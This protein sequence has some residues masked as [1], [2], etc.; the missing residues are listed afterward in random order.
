MVYRFPFPAFPIGWFRVAKSSDVRPGQ[1]KSIHY[2]GRNLVLWRS[3]EGTVRLFDS[4]CSHLGA[5]VGQG[6]VVENMIQ[7]PFHGWRF[8]A[9]GVCAWIPGDQKIP[10]KAKL[11]AWPVHEA[12]GQVMVYF[13][14]DGESPT[15]T[16]PTFLEASDPA[17]S[18]FHE[19]PGLPRIRTHVQEVMENGVDLRHI[20]YLHSKAV[21]SADSIDVQ[22]EGPILIHRTVQT[23][24]TF[25]LAK[26]F[27]GGAIRGPLEFQMV[28]LGAALTRA[29]LDVGFEIR[30]SFLFF[31]TPID[32]E[33]VEFNSMMSVKKFRSRAATHLLLKKA[34]REGKSIGNWSGHA[35][36]H[37]RPS[38]SMTRV[39]KVARPCLAAV[40][41]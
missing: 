7:C 41:R 31:S 21:V 23:Y 17:W 4:H 36:S 39:S 29:T 33:H 3:G 5:D 28:G 13:H 9:E 35:G 32:A 11:G 8:D 16:F 25:G 14:P 20:E 27:V 18:G 22:V 19:G 10:P 37:A 15:W 34:M 40:D 30:Y 1:L 24:N 38:A 2:F 12:N 6:A 26:K